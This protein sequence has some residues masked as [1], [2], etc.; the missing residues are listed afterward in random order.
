VTNVTFYDFRESKTVQAVQ[1]DVA[2]FNAWLI[3]NT[4]SGGENWNFEN[5]FGPTSKGHNLDSIYVYNNVP[6]TTA[7][8]PAVRIING[9]QLPSSFGLTI[10]TPQP[11]YVLGNYN[12]QTN[13]GSPV[14][15][16]TNT[17]STY[18][19]ALMGDAITI[20]SGNWRDS[21]DNENPTPNATTINAATLE[22]IVPSDPTINGS[23]SGGVENFLRLLENWAGVTLTY[24]GSIA[25]MFDSQYATNHWGGSYYGV[26]A[27]NWNFDSNFLNLNKLPP[28][29]PS[30][31]NFVTP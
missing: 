11:L 25:V 22:G 15:G 24:N 19:A 3:T 16:T 26:P 2:K 29:T 17:A 8:L 1:I 27:R 18:P 28:L 20:L 14:L 31:V 6:L 30:V 23:Y 13:G 12:V 7:Q 9:Q 5:T 4:A 21:V 10:A